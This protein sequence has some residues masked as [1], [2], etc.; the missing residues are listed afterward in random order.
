[1]V[2]AFGRGARTGEDKLWAVV[3]GRPVLA[4]TLESVAAAGCFDLVAV[5]APTSRWDAIRAIAAGYH[6]A[7][8]VL[9]EGGERRQ[10]SVAAAIDRCAGHP[11]ISVHDAARPLTPPR[12][13]Q[14]VLDAARADGAA[15]A[16]VP[17]VD[18]VKQV[19][20]GRV[21]ATLDRSSIIATQTPQSFGA[22]LLRRAHLNAAT[23]GISA[24]DDAALVEA[25]GEPVTV[26]PGDPRN[27][28]ITFPQD[29]VLLRALL[30][31]V[32]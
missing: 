25:L 14:T 19:Q 6:L 15:T 32:R 9:L 1:M 27:F 5:A 24:A 30:E 2:P 13:F 21:A 11:W 26:V 16:G 3:S 12:V 31:E 28:K 29:L 10:D 22:D 8:V 4:I 20:H 7:N 17:C 18:T 23:H